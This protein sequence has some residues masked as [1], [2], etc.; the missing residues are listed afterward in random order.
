[1]KTVAGN[2][3]R[4]FRSLRLFVAF[5][6]IQ[7]NV[8]K[9]INARKLQTLRRKYTVYGNSVEKIATTDVC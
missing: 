5:E 7:N 4:L 2:G 6:I 8:R 3:K 9:R 1:V